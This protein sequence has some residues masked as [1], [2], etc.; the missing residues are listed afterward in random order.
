[1]RM[2]LR[3]LCSDFI[4]M[5]KHIMIK[6]SRGLRQTQENHEDLEPAP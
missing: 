2:P 6:R 5:R 1:M 4:A 3:E